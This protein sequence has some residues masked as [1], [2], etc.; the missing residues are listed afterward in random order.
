MHKINNFV[1][2][3]ENGFVKGMLD[4]A[5]RLRSQPIKRKDVVNSEMLI[6]LSD[7]HLIVTIR[8]T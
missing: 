8:W 5:K 1:D 3:T 7:Q 4:A 2:P 6:S